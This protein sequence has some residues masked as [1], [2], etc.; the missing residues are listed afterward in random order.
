MRDLLA[1][2]GAEIIAGPSA[3]GSY[4]IRLQAESDETVMQALSTLRKQPDVVRFA[5]MSE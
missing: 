4:T 5:T 1:D 2:I 3:R